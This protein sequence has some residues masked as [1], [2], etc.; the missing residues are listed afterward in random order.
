MRRIVHFLIAVPYALFGVLTICCW[1]II[2]C[3]MIC[4][5][6]WERSSHA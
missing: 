1:P 4:D 3:F 5:A 2:G 6:L